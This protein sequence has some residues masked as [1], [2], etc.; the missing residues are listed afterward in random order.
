MN[1][2]TGETGAG[3]TM[4]V[5]GLG[6]LF[7]GRADAARVRADPGRAMVEGRV[8]VPAERSASVHER[9]VEAGAEVDPDG[10]LL[11]SRTVTVEG[12]SR[13][14][15]GGRA[16]PVSML[17]ELGEHVLAVHGQSDQLRLLRPAEQ[18]G[19]LDRYAGP[20][21]EKVL[22]QLREQFA[23]WRAVTDDLED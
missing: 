3:K 16:V 13:A 10:S 19:S 4:V 18:R 6:L 5:T 7:G 8:R 2:L 15:V 23:Q 12:R 11:L 21:H 20:D 17:S 14:H 22:V 1:V 9:I